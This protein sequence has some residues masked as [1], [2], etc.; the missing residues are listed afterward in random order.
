M[1]PEYKAEKEA[2]VSFLGG[3]GIWEINF[4]TVIAPVAALLWAIFQTRQSFFKPYT[5]SAGLLD[6]LL[7]CG[8]ILF[9]TTVYGNGPQI[10]LGLLFLPAVAVLLQPT[11]GSAPVP[12]VPS[13]VNANGKPTSAEQGSTA[14]LDPLPIK[15]FI[16]MYRGAMM[17]ITCTSILAVDFKVFPR[18]FA[19]TE[20]FGTSLMDM[21]VG[22][23]VFGA[24]MIAARQQLKEQLSGAPSIPNG[25][26]N[27]VR[28]ALPLA[29]LGFVR[30]WSV[31]GLEYAEHVSEYGVH[32]NFF[33]TLALL[34]PVTAILQPLLR[35]IPSLGGLTFFIACVYECALYFTP[36][37]KV[38]IILSE[39]IPGDWL[40]Q[41][42]EGVFSFIGYL[43]IFLAGMGT[44]RT[45]LAR[46]S[47]PE[48]EMNAA[49]G[50]PLDEDDEWLAEVLG[51]SD[52]NDVTGA[53]NAT[54]TKPAPKKN[55]PH[56]DPM[57]IIYVAN[58]KDD[59]IFLAKWTGIWFI[60]SGWALWHYGPRL[61]VSR[62]MANLPYIVWV[63]CFNTAQLLLFNLVQRL[64]FPNVHEAKDRETERQRV[65][66]ATSRVMHAFNRNGLAL[67]LL[68][69]L[70]TGAVNMAVPT[71][72]MDDVSA[73]AILVT[74]IAT[75]CGAGLLLDHYDIS[76]KL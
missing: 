38:Y 27:A 65:K 48:D 2:S 35:R 47:G 12:K 26:N 3:G 7:H 55:E 6:F 25:L 56:P 72:H 69:N 74:Y 43:A 44:G 15:P 54:A 46:D 52:Q 9:A 22:S 51:S 64:M 20:S 31:K 14:D 76:I 58:S 49:D 66:D 30:F 8:A 5:I 73:M 21:G 29:A 57:G 41:N 37:L 68:A 4:V 1:T 45:I 42:R 17:I 75:L 23:F 40:S 53:D 62:R 59:S 60:L 16:T 19:K 33:F 18:R 11:S 50:D 67:F 61:T 28:H 63:C 39:R 36:D 10:L 70:L 34:G 71:W 24:G 13:Q 32:W